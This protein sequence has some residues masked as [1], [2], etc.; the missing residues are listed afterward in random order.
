M[1]NS[2]NEGEGAFAQVKKVTNKKTK[3]VRAMKILDKKNIPALEEE[4]FISEIQ[5]LKQL[6]HPHILKLYEFY[7]DAKNY[8][9]IMELCTGGELFD[10]IINKGSFSEKEATYVMK[11][12]LSAIRYAHNHNIVH[13]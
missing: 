13:R 7:Q 1:I 12:L 3:T 9:I 2:P 5:V 6:D 4:K 10:Q 11:Q 8:Y